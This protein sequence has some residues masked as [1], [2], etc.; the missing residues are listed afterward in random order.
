MEIANKTIDDDFDDSY[1]TVED[2]KKL[3]KVIKKAYEL[4]H[5]WADDMLLRCL[6]EDYYK[7]VVRGMNKEDYLKEK[8]DER[9]GDL[10]TLLDGV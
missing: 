4:S 8:D 10:E 3:L 1:I 6:V 5:S 7:Q 9:R 2:K